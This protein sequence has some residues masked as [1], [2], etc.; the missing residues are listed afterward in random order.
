MDFNKKRYFCSHCKKIVDHL[1]ALYFVEEGSGRGFC[2]EDCIESF[3][4]PII[5][6]F[7]D[8]E[9]GLRQKYDLT[10][11]EV[12]D[13]L[14][15]TKYLETL[16]RAPQEVW[17]LENDLKEEIF[18]F[19]GHFDDGSDR[20]VHVMILCFVFNF[21]PSFIFLAT[22]TKDDRLLKEFQ[23]GSQVENVTPYVHNDEVPLGLGEGF[24]ESILAIIDNKKSI[25][26]GKLLEH[27]SE[28]DIP[29]EEFHL[30]EEY[31]KQTMED[32]DE[33][34]C[35]RDDDEDDLYT[36]IKAHE[37]DG[38]SFYCFVI[39]M[40]FETGQANLEKTWLPILA[41]PSLDGELYKQYC[42]GKEVKGGL[43]S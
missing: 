26:L 23:I 33:I 40:L 27:R 3:F 20:P 6:H 15:N 28:N 5:K 31:F 39:C 13:I 43:K 8:V 9:R 4:I 2:S 11:E 34:Y 12:P 41:F 21:Q 16:M 19:I 10:N 29:F 24:D 42:T 22:V 17:R 14:Q 1:D 7:E 30:Y 36:Y 35:D 32:P 38:T 18:T 25:L 37:K